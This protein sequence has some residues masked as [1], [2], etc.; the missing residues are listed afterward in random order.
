MVQREGV[1]EL[2]DAMLDSPTNHFRELAE[3][4]SMVVHQLGDSPEPADILWASATCLGGTGD[5]QS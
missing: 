4:D 5:S 2:G 3:R 1:A